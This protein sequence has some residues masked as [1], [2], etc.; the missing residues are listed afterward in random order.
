LPKNGAQ[1]RDALFNPTDADFIEEICLFKLIVT[2]ICSTI[3]PHGNRALPVS[4]DRAVKERSSSA[5]KKRAAL[6]KAALI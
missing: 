2:H 5:N 6:R 4:D 3:M 1:G